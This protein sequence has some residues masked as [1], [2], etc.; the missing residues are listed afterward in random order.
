M[1]INDVGG[2]VMDSNTLIA[3]ISIIGST[4]LGVITN[5]LIATIRKR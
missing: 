1:L 2:S 4:V 3:V 5:I